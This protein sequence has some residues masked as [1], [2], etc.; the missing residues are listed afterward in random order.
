MIE[1]TLSIDVEGNVPYYVQLYR[2]FQQEIKSK[3]IPAGTRLPAIRRLSEHL[4]ISRN[5]VE[6]AYMQLIAEG[7]VESRPRSGLYVVELEEEFSLA[8]DKVKRSSIRKMVTEPKK[9]IPQTT[10]TRCDFK[11]G[12]IDLR[13]FPLTVWNRLSYQTMQDVERYHLS[14]YGDP[15]GELGLRNQLAKYLR[16]SR[17]VQCSAE[18]IIVG[19]GSQHLLMLLCRL[20]GSEEQSIAVEEPGYNGAKSVFAQ[21][22]FN[23]LPIHLDEDG[24]NLE[25]LKQSE[26]KLVFVT[27]SHQF[28]LGMILPIQKRL[29]LL[30][31]AIETEGLIIEDDY[32]SEFRY[33]GRPIPSLQGLDTN[34]RVI[35]LGTFSKSLLSAIRISYMVLPEHLLKKFDLIKASLEPTASIIHTYTLERFMLEGWWEKHLRRMKKIY[36]KKHVFLLSVITKYLGDSVKVIGQDSG[37]HIV[38]EVLNGFSESELINRAAKKGVKIYSVSQYSITP[39]ELSAPRILLGFGKLTDNELEEGISLLQEAWQ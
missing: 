17:G 37:L 32:D 4:H 16:Q 22:N 21:L 35:Y 39:N 38:L 31:W 9:T 5:T 26:A 34:G 27:P 28:P 24:I 18:Q 14:Y 36:Q 1:I 13:Y 8:K 33:H 30:Q 6:A 11:N 19:A 10:E 20:L 25:L 29:K 3:H 23:M 2:Y 12:T 7:Y 15:Q